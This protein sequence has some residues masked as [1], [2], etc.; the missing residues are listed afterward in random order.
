MIMT[1]AVMW[2]VARN[3]LGLRFSLPYLVEIRT[4]II[5]LGALFAVAGIVQF[6]RLKT[7]V[8]PFKLTESKRLATTG[9]YRISRN[10]MYLGLAIMLL[11]W[12]IH[13]G[14]W[15]NLLPLAAFVFLITRWQIKPEEEALRQLFGE[16]YE[17]YCRKVRRWL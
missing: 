15:L 16:E 2:L 17:A 4:V 3:P 6:A 8:N 14:D 9:V 1:G 13:L 12:G 11:G 5:V 10:P 7:T